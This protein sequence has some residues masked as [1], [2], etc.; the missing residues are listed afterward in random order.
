[1]NVSLRNAAFSAMAAALAVW[2]ALM[3]NDPMAALIME[4]YSLA[5][6]ILAVAFLLVSLV[7]EGHGTDFYPRPPGQ[8]QSGRRTAGAK[9]W[10]HALKRRESDAG[11]E[12]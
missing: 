11:R 2:I 8:R 3:T 1:M 12:T 9:R 5:A 7:D 4:A 6:I 10:P